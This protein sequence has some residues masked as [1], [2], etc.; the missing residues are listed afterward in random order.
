[1]SILSRMK[2][3]P[4]AYWVV[5]LGGA[6]LAVDYL[7]EG[8]RSVLSS[9]YRGVFGSEHH[10]HHDHG[11]KSR[12]APPVQ[13]PQESASVSPLQAPSATPAYGPVYYQAFPSG[14]PYAPGSWEVIPRHHEG[15][16]EAYGRPREGRGHLFH[17]PFSGSASYSHA[18]HR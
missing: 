9:L 4:T 11:S 17:A 7:V 15:H 10:D 14:Y 6:A 3:A 2:N 16:H 13:S 1:M 5:G 12:E 18:R 8:H